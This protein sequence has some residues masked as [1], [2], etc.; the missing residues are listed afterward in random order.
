MH[1]DE[2]FPLALFL[3]FDAVCTI[4]PVITRLQKKSKQTS[5]GK[6]VKSPT[7]ADMLVDI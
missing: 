5:I 1:S 2:T 6:Q 4:S 3:F 7:P